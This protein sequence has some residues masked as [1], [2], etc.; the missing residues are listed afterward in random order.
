[1]HPFARLIE[2]TPLKRR[3]G[4]FGKLAKARIVKS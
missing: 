2:L 1:M 4:F 3:G